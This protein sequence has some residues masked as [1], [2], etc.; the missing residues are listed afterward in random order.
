[1]GGRGKSGVGLRGARA[2]ADA[3]VGV[4][5]GEGSV[6]EGLDCDWG[7]WEIGALRYGAEVQAL[8]DD[9]R[10]DSCQVAAVMARRWAVSCRCSRRVGVAGVFGPVAGV[11]FGGPGDDDALEFVFRDGGGLVCGRR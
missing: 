7:D 1:M 11:V 3:A 8:D 5:L 6:G 9:L 10:S 4:H 2:R